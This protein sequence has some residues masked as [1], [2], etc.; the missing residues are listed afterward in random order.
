MGRTR[1]DIE[2][3]VD[4]SELQS[5]LQVIRSWDNARPDVT[6][7]IAVVATDLSAKVV[8]EIIDSLRPP[9]PG[10]SVFIP[11]DRR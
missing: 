4:D 5:C 2:I 10:G 7:T 1:I 3:D 11:Y 6:M 8:K 9:F